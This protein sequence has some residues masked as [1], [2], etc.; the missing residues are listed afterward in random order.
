MISNP[1]KNLALPRFLMEYLESTILLTYSIS[2]K[3]L[4]ANKISSTYNNKQVIC[5]PI[6][7]MN[8]Q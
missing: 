8:R 6:F 5:S 4:P 2:Y 3:E 1:K 7:L